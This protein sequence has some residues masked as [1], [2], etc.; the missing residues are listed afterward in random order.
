MIEF[1]FMTCKSIGLDI[2]LGDISD[3][4]KVKAVRRV[5]LVQ[6]PPSR[7]NLSKRQR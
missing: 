7:S 2:Q 5:Y 1:V 6:Q 3:E 4:I